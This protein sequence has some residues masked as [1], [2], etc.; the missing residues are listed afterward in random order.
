MGFNQLQNNNNNKE[1]YQNNARIHEPKFDE[2]AFE[3]FFF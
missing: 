3:I 1:T 2:F